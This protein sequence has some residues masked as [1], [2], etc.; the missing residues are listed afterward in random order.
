VTIVE[1]ASRPDQRVIG[2]TLIGLP[3]AVADLDGPAVLLY[4][5]ASR[6]AAAHLT[7]WKEAL[8]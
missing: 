3:D 5:L 2:T 1:N 4:G 8:S 6:A 7:V